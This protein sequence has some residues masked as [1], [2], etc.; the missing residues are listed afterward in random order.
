M[1]DEHLDVT[2]ANPSKNRII[3]DA[4]VKIDRLDTKRLAHLLQAGMLAESC[5]PEDRIRELRELI[6][7]HKSLIEERTA[8]KDRVRAVLKRTNKPRAVSCSGRQDESS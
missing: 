5:V 1:L 6:R 7:A 4:T 3:A 2:L 8:E